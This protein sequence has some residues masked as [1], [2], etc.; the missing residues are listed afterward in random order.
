MGANCQ[1]CGCSSPDEA[2]E[3]ED[4][5]PLIL[6]ADVAAYLQV[7]CL[8]RASEEERIVRPGCRTPLLEDL[9]CQLFTLHDLN[10]DGL[11]QES[12]LIRINMTV[13]LLHRGDDADLVEVEDTYRT[14]F[15][16]KFDAHGHPVKYA[17]FRHYMLQLL[18]GIDRDPRAQE[19]MVE[20]FNAEAL[21]ARE[22]QSKEFMHTDLLDL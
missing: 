18:D 5:L 2:F 15:R 11:L 12:E 8:Q 22:V 19:M 16:E 3:L 6:K 14:L 21:L 10:G 20:Q 9:I 4:A 7:S 1:T 13:A 17:R